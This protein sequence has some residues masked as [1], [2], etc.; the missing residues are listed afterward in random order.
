MNGTDAVL[1]FF[2]DY[3]SGWFAVC[4][5]RWFVWFVLFK[6]SVV[7]IMVQ[8]AKCLYTTLPP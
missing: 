6:V 2:C 7:L 8:K 4:V 3:F 5:L 1:N